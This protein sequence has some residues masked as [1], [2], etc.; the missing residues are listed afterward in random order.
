MLNLSAVFM[1]YNKPYTCSYK[2][3]WATHQPVGPSFSY[4]TYMSHQ[5]ERATCR[6]RTKSAASN[7]YHLTPQLAVNNRCVWFNDNVLYT[8]DI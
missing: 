6:L 2:C 7:I 8:S 5:Q 3:I 1:F 4:V